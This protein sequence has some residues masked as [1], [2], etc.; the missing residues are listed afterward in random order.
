MNKVEPIR[1]IKKIKAMFHYLKGSDKTGR[2]ALLFRLGINS[3][4]RISDLLE[5]RYNDIFHG[6]YRFKE[7]IRI[8]EFK[9]NKWK[10]FKPPEKVRPMLK[11]YA[12]KHK[13][14]KEDYIFFSFR[15]GKS[16]SIDRTNTW[17]IISSAAKIVGIQNFGTHSLRKT[18]GYHYYKNTKD[19][20]TLMKVFNHGSQNIT[21]RYIGIEQENLDKV[22]IDVEE[23]Y[24]L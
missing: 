9:T 13:L 7:Y 19:I 15:S 21:L 22:Y 5:L 14:K 10:Q 4:L 20:A 11:S 17:R 8:R 16:V 1:S 12:K 24:N 6:N 23:Y 3:A 18:F 2:N